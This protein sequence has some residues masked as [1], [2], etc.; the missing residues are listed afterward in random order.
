MSAEAQST[1]LIFSYE[2]DSVRLIDQIPVNVFVPDEQP[3]SF[4]PGYYVDG[5]NTLNQRV[6]RVK[7]PNAFVTSAEV[8]PEQHSEAITRVTLPV[9]KGVFTVILPTSEEV[10]QV[11]I[12]RIVPSADLLKPGRAQM[13]LAGNVT[14]EVDIASFPLNLAR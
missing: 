8:F 4:P 11:T 1:R 14:S 2:G 5:R 3:D 13:G 6:A 12:V 9:S 10:H 7:A